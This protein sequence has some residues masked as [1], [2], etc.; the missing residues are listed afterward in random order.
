MAGGAAAAMVAR[1][2]ENS[3]CLQEERRCGLD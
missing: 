3:A 1:V 2:S